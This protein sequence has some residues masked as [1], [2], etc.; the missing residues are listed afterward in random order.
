MNITVRLLGHLSERNGFS[1]K[2]IKSGALTVSEL[3][4]KMNL[5]LSDYLLI[6]NG[7]KVDEEFKLTSDS[8]VV[9]SPLI[10]GG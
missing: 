6:V 5:D 9:F 1:Q 3:I 4:K 2:S 7:V 8:L 10:M